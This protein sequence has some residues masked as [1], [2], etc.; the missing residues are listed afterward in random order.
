MAGSIAATPASGDL[1][2]GTVTA[3]VIGNNGDITFTSTTLGPMGNGSGDTISY[4]EITASVAVLNSAV[5]LPHPTL[6]DG[7]TT[8]VSLTPA[9]GSKVIDR[10]ARW[11]FSYDNTNVVAPGTY[12]TVANNGRVTYTASML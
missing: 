1:N 2:N 5:A 8:T 12:G 10:D 11:T 9:T 6:A 4:N 7:A 3:R